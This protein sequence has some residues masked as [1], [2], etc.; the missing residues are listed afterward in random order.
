MKKIILILAI[1]FAISPS[2]AQN[3]PNISPE[4]PMLSNPPI[5]VMPQQSCPMP[6]V[7]VNVTQNNNAL[8]IPV[9]SPN[10]NGFLVYKK[11]APR[12]VYRDRGNVTFITNHN[13]FGD[14]TKK[15]NEPDPKPN[16]QAS[17]QTTNWDL[18]AWFMILVGLVLITVWFIDWYR[19]NHPVTPVTPET[20]PTPAAPIVIRERAPQVI[21]PLST[22]ELDKAMA[23]AKE[24]GGTFTKS[25]NGVGYSVAFPKPEAK[26]DTEN[27]Q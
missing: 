27:P 18:P 13:Y 8:S 9:P 10:N 7:V 11:V 6:P 5:M 20:T 12:I 2:F 21:I 4:R 22:E 25:P 26:K 3:S 1:M 24:S 15:V 16:P 14:T 19:R 23:M 17:N